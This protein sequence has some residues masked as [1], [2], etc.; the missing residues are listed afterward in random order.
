[1]RYFLSRAID[2]IERSPITLPLFVMTF[3][4]L[5]IA[6]LLVE[7]TLGFFQEHSLFSFF[8]E[9]S[10]TFLFFLCSFILMVFLVRFAGDTTLKKATNILLFGFLII[11]TPPIIDRLIMGAGNYWSFYE[12]DGFFGLLKRYITLFG[13]TPD[14]GITYGVRVEVVIVTLLLGLYSFI[15]SKRVLKALLVSLLAYT[16]LFILGTFPAW[17]TLGILSLEKSFF[18]ISGSDVA[19]LFLTP[20]GIFSRNLTDFRSVLNVKMSIVYSVM[21]FFL[22][23][24]LLYREFPRY[25]F[26]LWKNIRIPQ[27]IYHGGL[28]LL[29]M[30]LAFLFTEAPF[31][32]NF[33]HITGALVLIIAVACAW[34]ASVIAND[35]FDKHIDILTNINRPLIENTVPEELYK[36]FGIL[37]FIASLLLSGI[38]SFSALFLLL[39]YQAIA[40]LYSA[41]PLRLKR[42][43]IIATLFAAFAGILILITG[44]LAVSPG[45]NVHTLPLPLLFYL[46]TAYALILPIKD[47]KDIRGD[48]QDHIYTFPVVLGK[49][50]AKLLIGSLTFLLYAFSPLILNERILFFP[51]LFFGSLA[52]WIIQKG[53]ESE[54]TFFSFRKLPGLLIIVTTCYGVVIASLLF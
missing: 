50:K 28:L 17:L 6:R 34:I 31:T 44:F 48:A 8:F 25:F 45:N 23:S 19:A 46:F 32:L 15:K 12:F 49:E 39:A 26:A 21:A 51:A 1:M 27:I 20:E 2:S 41:P 5:I 38:I 14:I 9:F 53:E 52:F 54:S 43:P 24:T 11:L 47:F 35:C 18:A 3:F 10:H 30:A 13:D 42:Y 33:F 16:I 36:T 29:G 40:W 7:N 4:T 22:A 37:F